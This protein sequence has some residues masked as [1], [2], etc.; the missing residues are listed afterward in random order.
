MDCYS[1]QDLNPRTCRFS[2]KCKPGFTRN[3][4]F[5]CRKSKKKNSPLNAPLNSPLNSPLK[6]NS[7]KLSL[8]T[9]IHSIKNESPS[10]PLKRVFPLHSQDLSE[11]DKHY[12]I[13]EDI[14]TGIM[15][16]DTL[17]KDG[18]MLQLSK[19]LSKTYTQPPNG[20]YLS[21]KY[22]GLRG[23]WTGKELVARP[24]KK[25]G[26]MKGKVFNYV[27][28]WFINLLPRG[29]SLDGELWLGR[30]KFQEISGLSN[31]KISKKIT[32]EYLDSMWKDVKFML[33]D[34]PHLNLPYI[35]RLQEL[36]KIV[37]SIKIKQG[38]STIELSTQIIVKD[39][40]HLS[41][42]YTDYI[43]NGAE[44]IIL[45]EPNSYYET[46]R[47]KLLLKM[48]LNNDAEAT[49]TG[50][51]LGTGKYKGMLGS[52]ICSINGKKFNIGTG[53]NDKMRNEYNDPESKYYMPIGSTVNFGYMEL[54]KD[55][56]P[57]HP[58][59]RGIRTDI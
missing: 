17:Y 25:D 49:I 54:T 32:K 57:R 1:K 28:E 14:G 10:V 16:A 53:F 42:L 8:E 19:A 7:P 45:R 44:G 9:M 35:D 59:Y 58:V 55:G 6:L 23:I 27:P 4:K 39:A 11:D 29:V 3:E 26:V 50:Y 51:L 13:F 30:G 40:E 37:D 52:L 22:D 33:F 47:S 21:E 15:L 38:D 56:I 5:L 41:E 31:Y 46:K 20:W 36:K 48:K 18:K 34:I 12:I 43:I 24:S 2:L